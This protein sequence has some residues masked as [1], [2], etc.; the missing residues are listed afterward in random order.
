MKSKLLT[1][2]ALV[3]V[4]LLTVQCSTLNE[5]NRIEKG[6]SPISYQTLDNYFVRNDVE[7]KKLQKLIFDNEND[8][9]AYFG[10]AA[11]MGSN[12]MPTEVN[13]KTQYVMAVVLPETDRSTTVTPI[14]VS[15]NGVSV[16]LYYQVKRGSR[17]SYTM[18][19]FTAVALDKPASAQQQE[20]YFIEK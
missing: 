7:C 11:T 18:V 3:G 16:I 10:E 13:W 12:G 9:H 15:Q 14:K 6:A 8:F 20:F 19:P 2:L 4:L 5:F 1:A 17:N